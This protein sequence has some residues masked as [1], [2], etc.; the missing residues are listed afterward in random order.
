M[1]ATLSE[2][3]MQKMLR[4]GKKGVS[5]CGK[6]Y[7]Q[8]L[9]AKAREGRSSGDQMLKGDHKNTLLTCFHNYF[10]QNQLVEL[11]DHRQS[12]SVCMCVCVS[13]GYT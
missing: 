2:K 8:M 6:Y 12:L 9:M 5:D 13:C 3:K 11:V 7:T 4:E 10:Q 1:Q